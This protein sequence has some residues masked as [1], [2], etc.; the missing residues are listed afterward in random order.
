[1]A[2][3]LLDGAG[4]ARLPRRPLSVT[5]AVVGPRTSGV[6]LVARLANGED[7]PVRVHSPGMLIV[8]RVDDEIIIAAVPEP[9]LAQFDE[10]TVLHVTIG[11]DSP[12]D[13]DADYAQLAPREVSGLASIELATIAPATVDQV[14]VTTRLTV[15]DAPLPPLSSRA[16]VACRGALGVD[17][18]P[19][20]RQVAPGCVIAASASVAALVDDGT[21]AAATDIVAG[22]T[23]VISGPQPLRA[24]LADDKYTEVPTGPIG[25]LAARVQRTLGASGYGIGANLDAAVRRVS[26]SAGFIVVITNMAMRPARHDVPVSLMVLSESARRYPGF[27]GATFPPPPAGTRAESFYD[28]NPHLIDQAVAALVAPLRERG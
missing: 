20:E 10:D 18:L 24:C 7:A 1:M 12:Q 26:H 27:S 19:P 22:I 4:S 13:I 2:T 5:L 17:T 9:G 15:A 14:A 11:P 3:Y 21:L 25:E 23:A 28:A 8:P 6:R 16:R